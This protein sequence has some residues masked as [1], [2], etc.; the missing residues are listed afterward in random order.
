MRRICY[1][2][3]I[4]HFEIYTLRDRDNERIDKVN[5]LFRQKIQISE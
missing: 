2:K 5:K 4:S 3:K 1:E